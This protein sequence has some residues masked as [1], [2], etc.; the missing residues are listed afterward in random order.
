MGEKTAYYANR[1]TTPVY[2]DDRYELVSTIGR[3]KSSVVYLACRYS[4][5]ETIEIEAPPVALKILL[6]TERDPA[7]AM[8]RI[9]RESLALLS[10]VHPSIIRM[11]D[12]V[13][14]EDACYVSMEYAKFGD[15]KN[16]L[17]SDSSFLSPHATLKLAQKILAGVGAIHHA[18]ILHR[19]L[20]PDNILLTQDYQVKI[21]DFSVCLLKGEKPN[22]QVVSDIV[23]TIDYLAP[24]CLSG[25]GYSISSDLYSVSVSI[26]ELLTGY[27]PFRSKS[28]K[29]SLERKSL[30]EF[31]PLPPSV[32]QKYPTLNEFFKKAF[33]FES[34]K[35]FL[36][37]E[38]MAS[39][40]EQVIK[41]TFP[42]NQP[43]N[44]STTKFESFDSIDKF[45]FNKGVL[46]NVQLVEKL[47][48]FSSRLVKKI[49]SSAKFF[50]LGFLDR[51][52]QRLKSFL[53]FFFGAFVVTLLFFIYLSFNKIDKSVAT[54]KE[55]KHVSNHYFSD[56][57]G[58]GVLEGLYTESKDY[59]FV[60][61]PVSDSHVLFG[62][63]VKGWEPVE[64]SLEQVED[65]KPIH[66]VGK[67]LDILL[68]ITDAQDGRVVGT[69]ENLVTARIGKWSFSS[70]PVMQ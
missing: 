36:S 39:A 32:L 69:Y 20:K 30:S 18:G 59:K 23:G 46:E 24:E 53:R 49:L 64:V 56:W 17:K 57:S 55:V 48:E 42:E 31:E 52:M 65:G 67:G 11:H 70:V 22:L 8:R 62:L 41:G 26:F 66:I 10:C 25:Q 51:L 58:V 50:Q 44:R 3:G 14:R 61:T 5:D 54:I 6:S 33:E 21:C 15:L 43:E 47:V 27:L 35:R 28:L 13:A 40:I 7:A 37:H 29:E 2:Y 38:Q 4:K 45:E 68:K 60:L 16:L 12:Y 34:S 19:D 9:K 63:L 1:G